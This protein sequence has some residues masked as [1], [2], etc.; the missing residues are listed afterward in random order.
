[1]STNETS[2]RPTFTF[3]GY[4]I[5]GPDEFRSRVARLTDY[6][7]EI[8]A[9]PLLAAA[10]DL[11]AACQE[12]QATI[13]RFHSYFPGHLNNRVNDANNVFVMLRQAIAKATG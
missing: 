4:G 2:N 7:Q 9:G 10:P 8:K 3:D 5:N 12:A 1:M 6:G 11:L 13:E